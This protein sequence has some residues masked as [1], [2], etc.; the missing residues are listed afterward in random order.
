MLKVQARRTLGQF[1]LDAEFASDAGVTALFGRSGAGKTTL[2]HAIAGLLRPERGAIEINGASLFDSAG[3]I[4]VPVA[5]RRVGYV[6]QE[7]RLFPHLTVRGN[8][9]FGH[10]LVAPR[11]RYVTI[12][13]VVEL[14]GLGALLERRPANLSGGEKQR[15][16]IGRALLA[17]PRVLLMDEPLA[18]LDAMR[19]SE[20][21]QYIERLHDEISVP[22]V[23]VTHAIE[24]IVRLAEAVVVMAEGK[25]VA[26]GNVS[27]IMGR[28]ELRVQT[29]RFEGGSVIE[30]RVVAQ[31]LDYDLATLEFTG[32]KLVAPAI[33]ALVGERVRVRVRARDVSLALTRPSGLS[34]LNVL[35]GRVIAIDIDEGPSATVHVDVGGATMLARITRFSAHRLGIVPGREVYALIKAVS[36]D[37]SRPGPT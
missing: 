37:R 8:L 35:G 13:Q 16:A 26:S 18:A 3:G 6:F 32:G 20:I 27:D 21:L 24:E 1:T 5:R 9:R 10:D 15:V 19:K 11:E 30:A 28:P 25:V 34:V 7:G 12:D 4:D 23:Y 14:L 29:G 2:V 31:D 17:S 36:L 33:D 22:I